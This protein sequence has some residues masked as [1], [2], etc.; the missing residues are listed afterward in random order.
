[1]YNSQFRWLRSKNKLL[2]N[3]VI[4]LQMASYCGRLKI[5]MSILAQSGTVLFGSH[6][7]LVVEQVYTSVTVVPLG[8]SYCL[9][10]LME[11][12][13]PLPAVHVSHA[14]A[15][16]LGGVSASHI[17]SETVQI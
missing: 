2:N 10:Q 11:Q 17:F 7:P 5:Y 9:L 4:A 8:T 14:N 12:C 6:T 1:M 13:V 3:N 16:F 15:P